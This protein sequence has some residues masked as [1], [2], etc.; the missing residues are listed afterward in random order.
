MEAIKRIFKGLRLLA[1]FI[2]ACVVILGIMIIFRIHPGWLVAIA[3][4][5]TAW[6]IGK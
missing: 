1:L 6:E 5:Q 4:I 3:V 2:L